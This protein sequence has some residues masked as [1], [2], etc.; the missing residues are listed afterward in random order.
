[1]SKVDDGGAAFPY[2]VAYVLQDGDLVTGMSLRDYFAAKVMQGMLAGNNGTPVVNRKHMK[3]EEAA[4]AIAD[5]MIKER[6]K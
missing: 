1:M 4:Y 6:E 5:A 2:P 3:L